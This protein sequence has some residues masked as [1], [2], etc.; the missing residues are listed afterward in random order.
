MAITAQTQILSEGVLGPVART[1]RLELVVVEGPDMGRAC[2]LERGRAVVVGS[3]A[4]AELLLTDERV[5]RKHV[6]LRLRDDGAVE[7]EDLGS[8]NGTLLEGARVQRAE[9]RAGATLKIGK[10]FLRLLETP[11]RVAVP[12]SQSRRF[13]ELVAESLA[14]REVFAVLERVAESDVTVLLEGET[15]VGKELAARA[16][17][18]ASARSK[19]PFVAIDASALP[20]ALVESELFGH[21]KGA[22]TGATDARKGAF[23][24]AHGGTLFLDELATVPPSVQVR[25]LR[26]L[27]ERKVRAVGADVEKRVEVRVIAASREPLAHRVA[28]GTFRADLLYRLGV[29]TVAIPPLRARREDLVP[30]LSAMLA[31]RGKDWPP[32]GPALARLLAHDWPG[33]ARE[34]R[35]VLDRALALA[36]HAKSFEELPLA[37]GAS[38]AWPQARAGREEPLAVRSD[39]PFSEAKQAVIDAFERAYLT[40][41]LARTHGNLSEAARQTGLDRKHLRELC[42]KHGLR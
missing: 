30:M 5:S 24:H 18:A 22:F 15:G 10:T 4:G 31:A 36:P 9:A 8:R 32:R 12:P 17:H 33:N 39:L 21:V 2:G 35:N 20:E 29:V 6:S 7:V 34:L 1:P 37:L 19:G 3:E 27:E 14:M 13:G 41:V 40:D 11:E 16:L 23:L 28:E 26:V 38:T 42:Q 25:L